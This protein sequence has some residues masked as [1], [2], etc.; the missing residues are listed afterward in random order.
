MNQDS[1][2]IFNNEFRYF[3]AAQVLSCSCFSFRM[4]EIF[5]MSVIFELTLKWSRTHAFGI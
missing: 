5:F 2:I 3:S 4:A 1:M